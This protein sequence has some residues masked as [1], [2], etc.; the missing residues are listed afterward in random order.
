MERRITPWKTLRL[1]NLPMKPSLLQ[2]HLPRAMG[3]RKILIARNPTL[4]KGQRPDALHVGR[5]VS[6]VMRIDQLVT[7]ASS[8]NGHARGIANELSSRPR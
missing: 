4:E 6:S 8:L 7:I 5:D 2:I 3:G 1:I